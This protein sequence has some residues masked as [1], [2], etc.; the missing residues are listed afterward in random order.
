MVNSFLFLFLY[1]VV[2]GQLITF[3][4]FKESFKLKER[5][6]GILSTSS[7]GITINNNGKLGQ[8]MIASATGNNISYT[9]T[10]LSNF[11]SGTVKYSVTCW[12]KSTMVSGWVVKMGSSNNIGLWF[13]TNTAR[14]VWNDSDSGKR[15]ATVANSEDTTNWHHLAIVIDKTTI[16][17]IKYT[18]YFDG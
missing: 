5:L 6:F 16:S 1:S 17:A 12:V 8:C 3:L 14:W 7:S 9:G 10:G 4:K 15:I 13:G 2:L 18:F 11:F